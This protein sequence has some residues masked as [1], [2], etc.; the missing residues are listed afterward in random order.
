MTDNVLKIR[1]AAECKWDC[2]SF[3]E[4]ML[5]FDPGFGR[6]RN[7]RQFQVWEGGGEYN[8]ARAM[9]KCWGKRATIV[10]ALPV[11]DLG[12]LV[13]DFICQGGVDTSHII[14][15]EHDGIG[16]NTRVGLNFTEKGFGIR[17]ALGCSDRGHSAA[18]QVRPG[19]VNWEKL[20]GEEGV[21]WFHTGGIFA[22]L[23]PNTSEAVIE[24][25]EVARKHGTII[26]YDLNYRASLW[27]SQGGKE[28]AQ[29][30]NRKIAGNVDVMIGNEED[31][32]ACLGF[33]VEGLDEQLSEIDPANF[34]K[35]I[36]TAVKEFPNFRVAATTLR[37]AKTASFNDWSAILYAGGKFYQS[38][39]REDLEIYD[40]VGGG[41]GFASGLAF[42]FLEGKGPQAAVD[43][44][45]AHGALAMTTPGDTSMVNAKEVEAIMKGKGA[46]V[47]R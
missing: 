22:A 18:S 2:A 1:P 39:T 25:V 36:A 31:F 34:K 6:V 11:N 7:A 44:G 14:W 27:K 47:I 13:E 28:G 17:A 3:G 4:V 32:T 45:A 15:R 10:T 41:D 26:S 12:W 9:G 24:A 16:R 8:V 29:K 33:K 43:Y 23:A 42:A 37:N 46:R 38:M 40:R 5:R 19:E 21:R 30:I 20:F 35:M